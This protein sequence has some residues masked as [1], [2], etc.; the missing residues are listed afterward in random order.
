MMTGRGDVALVTGGNRGLGR[1]AARELA[2][3]GVT[4]LLG[5]RD[6]GRGAEVAAEL[7][8]EGAVVRP[9][10]LDV[11]DPAQAGRAAE[12]I[13][14]DY[15]RL[16]ILVNNAGTFRPAPAVATTVRSLR[17]MFEVNVFGVVTVTNALLPLLA[18]S[19]WPRIVNVSSTTASMT[20]TADGV[21]LP[22]NAEV[23]MAYTASKAALNM[24]TVQYAQA[25]LRDPE[26]AHVKIN[27]VTPGYTATDMNA[28]QGERSVHDGARV[29]VDLAMLPPDGPTGGFFDDQGA[30]PW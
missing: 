11:T 12:R 19:P 13:R 14:G 26:Y 8:A 20:L 10:R 28:Y 2:H 17:E 29:I 23:R 3:K 5:S 15:G 21:D 18:R 27:S 30:V 16:D 4:V 24:L 7:A 6:A 9:V 25:F 22:G 1:E